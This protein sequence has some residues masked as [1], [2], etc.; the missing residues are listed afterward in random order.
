MRPAERFGNHF[1]DEAVL[2]VVAGGQGEGLGG[3]VLVCSLADFHRI[4]A[5]PSGEITE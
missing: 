4:A 5:Q 2:Q 3:G 1:I